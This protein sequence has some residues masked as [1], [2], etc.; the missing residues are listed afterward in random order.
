MLL[1]DIEPGVRLTISDA[2]ESIIHNLKQRFRLYRHELPVAHVTDVA[3]DAQLQKAL[4]GKL[5]DNI[6][7]DAP[8]SGSGT[9]ART[10]E[11]LYFFDPAVINKFTALQQTIATNVCAHL[12]PGGRLIYITCSVFAQENEAVAD[13]VIKKTGLQLIQSQ[14][15]NGTG[16]QADSMF[17]AMLKK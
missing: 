3:N 10:P 17:V 11:Q 14:L 8:C 4:G 6:I 5:F 1:K 16:I 12:K 2:R 13:A 15:I 9:W 7:C